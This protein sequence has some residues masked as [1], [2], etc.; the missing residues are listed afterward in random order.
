MFLRRLVVGAGPLLARVKETTGIVGLD[1]KTLNEIKVVPEDEGY[2]KVVES[3]TKNRLRVCE[4]EEDWEHI[5][6]IGNR[7]RWFDVL[8][9][10]KIETPRV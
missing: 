3:F 7:S 4:E 1:V 10:H 6:K 5:E 8:K 2:R 9:V